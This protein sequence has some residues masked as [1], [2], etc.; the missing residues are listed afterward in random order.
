MNTQVC[1][2]MNEKMNEWMM[3][4]SIKWL[5]NKYDRSKRER[6]KNEVRNKLVRKER[7]YI[8]VNTE[9]KS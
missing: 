3:N 6:G 7:K 1:E 4:E 9:H 5:I 2:W 8:T